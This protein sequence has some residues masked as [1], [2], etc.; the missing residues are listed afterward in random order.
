MHNIIPWDTQG[1]QGKN[2]REI[3]LVPNDTRKLVC[4]STTAA[5]PTMQLHFLTVP[6][7]RNAQESQERIDST[8]VNKIESKGIAPFFFRPEEE[9]G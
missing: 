4:H 2:S 3:P 7:Q 5:E 9:L 6:P 8:F 1:S